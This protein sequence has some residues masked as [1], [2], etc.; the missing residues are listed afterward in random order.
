MA[1]AQGQLDHNGASFFDKH[2]VKFKNILLLGW[3]VFLQGCNTLPFFED[4]RPNFLIIITDDQRFDTME[5]MPMTKE[6]IFDQG[7]TF[8]QGYVT[9]PYCCPS[10]SS[11][12][13]GLYAHNHKVLINDDKLLLPTVM[14]DLQAKGYFT[15]LIGKYLNSWT[16][17]PRPEFDYWVSFFGGTPKRYY[18]PRLN[19]N[20]DRGKVE[21]YITYIFRD[22]VL[23]F[24]DQASRRK[25]PFFL[26]FTPNAPHD[27][28]TPAEED[29]GLYLNLPPHR[30]PNFNEEDLSDK[31]RSVSNKPLLDQQGMAHIDGIRLA[32]L[33]TLASL[34]RS[35]GEIMQKLE[36]IGELDQ[37][38][39]V[40]LSDNGIHW[41]EHRM[42][43]KNSAYEESIRV[44]FAMRYPTLVPEPY[45]EDRL[46]ANIDIAPTIYE[47]SETPIPKNIDGSSLAGLFKPDEAWRTHLLLEAWPPR[48][49][50]SA[51]HTGQYIYIETENDLFEFYDLQV[52]PYQMNNMIE[53]PQYRDTI[54]ELR[55]M[56]EQERQPRVPV[57]EWF[58]QAARNC[59]EISS[60]DPWEF[61]SV[62]ISLQF[63][64]GR[65]EYRPP[66]AFEL[67]YPCA[68][69][70]R[71]H[72]GDKPLDPPPSFRRPE[73]RR[74]GCRYPRSQSIHR[75][76]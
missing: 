32:Q 15:G 6:L 22:H 13:T 8:S 5:F 28:F 72:D 55:M 62:G 49:F 9:T 23:E 67:P 18:G 69:R 38:M 34:D 53:E 66:R 7:V 37:T 1:H 19:I 41:G 17:S 11:I 20:G 68:R 3:L 43:N 51:I 36:D 57:A 35:I 56:L 44:P 50:W 16:D 52:D 2:I 27:P 73:V 58:Q 48:G 60:N 46:V 30:P 31:P 54:A 29:L 14:D 24:L 75:Q 47:L 76:C 74:R 21:G 65:R 45:I 33:Q 40:F 42:D 12:F 71:R 61:P 4:D 39:V 59:V 26:L 70:I 25:E 10:R 64:P 63:V